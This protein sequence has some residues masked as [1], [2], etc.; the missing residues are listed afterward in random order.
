MELKFNRLEF[1]IEKLKNNEKF[2]F[3]R[4]GDGEW[5]CLFGHQGH[6]CDLHQYFP[7]MSKG[8]Q[9][10]VKNYKGYYLA[11][12]P[13]TVP[14]MRTE[15]GKNA[16]EYIDYHMPGKNWVDARIW[17]NAA[18]DATIGPLVEQLKNMNFVMISESS[19]KTL[20]FITDFIEVPKKDCFLEKERIKKEMIE[21]TEKYNDVVFGLSASMATNVIVDELYNQIGN[22]CW[23][24][25]FGSIWDPYVGNMT[26]SY[27]RRYKSLMI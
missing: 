27:H 11:T 23:M 8:L 17:E 18:M 14:M 2:S 24:I 13:R 20:P 16:Y 4:W 3:T 10:A 7:E 1:Y 15:L 6:N 26:R 25:D 19:K 21:M 12:W 9:E 5:S 22:K